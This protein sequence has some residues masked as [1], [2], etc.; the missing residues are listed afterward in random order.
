MNS[1]HIR[2]FDL[3]VLPFITNTNFNGHYLSRKQRKITRKR[4]I[5][6][7]IQ[8]NQR[9]QPLLSFSSGII[10]TKFIT[11]LQ[12]NKQVKNCYR[13]VFIQQRNKE[14]IDRG[15]PRHQQYHTQCSYFCQMEG[16]TDIFLPFLAFDMKNTFPF[17]MRISDVFI[18]VGIKR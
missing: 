13:N 6:T 17:Q 12:S 11:L 18:H 9:N 5:I 7:Q 16:I 10:N 14:E 4:K 1:S 2:M 15:A 3:L 8:T